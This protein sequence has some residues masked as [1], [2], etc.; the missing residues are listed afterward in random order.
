MSFPNHLIIW[1]LFPPNN[2][3]AAYKIKEIFREVVFMDYFVLR[4]SQLKDEKI[5]ILNER[6]KS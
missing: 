3:F 1:L 5:K 6:C 2:I 4:F